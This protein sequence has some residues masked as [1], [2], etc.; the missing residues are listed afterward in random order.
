[1][2]WHVCSVRTGVCALPPSE[3]GWRAAVL[4]ETAADPTGLSLSD[5]EAIKTEWLA[6]T[7]FGYV[8]NCW[9]SVSVSMLLL[10]Q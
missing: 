2:G 7:H 4:A 8:I 5:S 10:L 3:R 9:V 6:V 1:M